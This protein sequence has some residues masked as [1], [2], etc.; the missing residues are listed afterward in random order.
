MTDQ[1]LRQ[2]LEALRQEISCME[3]IDAASRRRLER[4]TQAI[5]HKLEQP[6]DVDH[7]LHLVGL[8]QDEV[9]YFEASHP[10][11]AMA[12]NEILTTLSTAGV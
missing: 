8:L 5:E 1:P 4:L 2:A 9:A 10:R 6:Q 7:H 3:D 12:L 11:L